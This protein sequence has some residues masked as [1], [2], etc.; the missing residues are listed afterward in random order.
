MPT[1]IKYTIFDEEI[2]IQLLSSQAVLVSDSICNFLTNDKKTYLFS[3]FEI[4]EGLLCVYDSVN[5]P[6]EETQ[7]G[8]LGRNMEEMAPISHSHI[9]M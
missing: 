2:P 8:P 9:I 7:S 1:L 5:E 4:I 6:V 3:I